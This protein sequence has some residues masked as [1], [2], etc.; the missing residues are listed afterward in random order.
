MKPPSNLQIK[1]VLTFLNKHAIS[2]KTNRLK[3]GEAPVIKCTSVL[4][5]E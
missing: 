4:K 1:S 2:V 3:K 5:V